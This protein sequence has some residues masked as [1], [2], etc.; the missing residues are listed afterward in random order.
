MN[1]G[2]ILLI[3]VGLAFTPY[4]LLCLV[5]PELPAGYAG[6]A[7]PDASARTEVAAMYGGLQIGLGLLFIAL[8]LRKQ[9]VTIGLAVLMSVMGS[10]ALG[11]LYGLFAFGFSTYNFLAFLFEILSA[12]LAVVV[13]K[14]S[15]REGLPDAA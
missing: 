13:L 5:D 10:L 12:V 9:T 7:L 4:G 11:R 1:W 15:S 14:R 6:M 3:A 2:R 8:A